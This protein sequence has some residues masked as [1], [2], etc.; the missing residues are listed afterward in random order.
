MDLSTNVVLS[1]HLFYIESS[2]IQLTLQ[3]FHCTSV[4]QN[5]LQAL[6]STVHIPDGRIPIM[7]TS[8]FKINDNSDG[9]YPDIRLG[10]LL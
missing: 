2:N 5:E 10:W 1:Y 7:C 4:V 6:W 9:L 8:I 3:Y